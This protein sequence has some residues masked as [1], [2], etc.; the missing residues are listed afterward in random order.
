MRIAEAC[1]THL[2]HTTRWYALVVRNVRRK[3]VHQM[4]GQL[5]C[6]EL[7][8]PRELH[9]TQATAPQSRTSVWRP[10]K[11]AFITQSAKKWSVLTHF[12]SHQL[13][14]SAVLGDQSSASVAVV[15]RPLQAPF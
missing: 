9:A 2:H 4:H 7:Q 12:A 3:P 15:F 10:Y 6:L 8:T 13:N 5:S 1:V 14:A 11:T